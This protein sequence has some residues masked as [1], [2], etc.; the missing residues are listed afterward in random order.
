LVA[1]NT[2]KLV[3]LI[4][5]IHFP[6]MKGG[7]ETMSWQYVDFIESRRDLKAIVLTYDTRFIENFDDYWQKNKVL[8]IRVETRLLR[9]MISLKTRLNSFPGRV[10]YVLLHLFYLSKGTILFFNRIK[11]ADVILANGGAIES[12][13][14]YFLSIIIKKN[15]LIRWR[16]DFKFYLSNPV[17]RYLLRLSFKKATKIGVNGKD[18]EDEVNKFLGINEG[19]KVFSN[20]QT[21]NTEIFYPLS[22]TYVR[23]AKLRYEKFVILF[24]APFNEAKFCDIIVQAAYNLILND[25]SFF[26]IF[27]GHGPLDSIV[28]KLASSFPKNVLLID[29]PVDPKTLSLYIN[30]ADITI[31]S[32][33]IH[34][35]GN[36]VVESLACGTS[37]LVF[38]SSIHENKRGKSLEFELPLPH[39]FMADPSADRLSEV[40]KTNKEFVKSLK[41][42]PKQVKIAQNYILQNYEKSKVLTEEFHK[43]NI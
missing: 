22:T 15:L 33:D 36:L 26:F 28:K 19:Q 34:Y 10:A 4:V 21:A 9:F 17:N 16:T 32:A 5:T 6:P 40:L 3:I 30:A 24:A 2:I 39:V 38:N 41:R 8:R 37:V 18:I 29:H 1:N 14:G 31:G 12:I 13:F 25:N 35:V 43:F 27:I 7:V 11:E 23:G 42:D 20:K